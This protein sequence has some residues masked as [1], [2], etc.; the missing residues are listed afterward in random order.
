LH[1]EGGFQRLEIRVQPLGGKHFVHQRQSSG[2]G[3]VELMS[4]TI[5]VLV[6]EHHRTGELGAGIICE[7]L[8]ENRNIFRTPEPLRIET[9]CKHL[10]VQDTG[11]GD[12]SDAFVQQVGFHSVKRARRQR[13]GQISAAPSTRLEGVVAAN[14]HFRLRLRLDMRRESGQCAR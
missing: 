4:Q 9:A 7:D 13:A 3:V 12:Q 8:G 11:P 10:P 1:V 5:G 14:D 2:L 6:H